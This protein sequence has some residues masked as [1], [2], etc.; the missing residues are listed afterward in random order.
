MNS[1]FAI[2]KLGLMLVL[3]VFFTGCS[4]VPSA[5]DGQKE[6]QERIIG[7]SPLKIVGFRK[8]IGQKGQLQNTD[9]V[10]VECYDLSY[11]AEIEAT[12]RC[13]LLRP[14]DKDAWLATI[15][16]NDPAFPIFTNNVLD[17]N[18]CF[19]MYGTIVFEKTE[20]GWIATKVSKTIF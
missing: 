9:G 8:T 5:D 7:H 1:A 19:R 14:E 10:A 17:A 4:R 6:I 12:Q 11:E 13:E 3:V 15:G 16:D 2:L 18:Q 20:H